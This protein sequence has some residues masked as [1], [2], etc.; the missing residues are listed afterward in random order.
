MLRKEFRFYWAILL[1]VAGVFVWPC[2]GGMNKKG[3]T[4][5]NMTTICLFLGGLVGKKLKV[6]FEIQESE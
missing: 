2:L 4:L 3:Q 5:W 6:F 1:G